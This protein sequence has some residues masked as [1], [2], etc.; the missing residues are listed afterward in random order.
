MGGRQSVEVATPNFDRN[1][2]EYVQEGRALPEEY[3]MFQT[4][5]NLKT[6]A[7][8]DEYE[9]VWPNEE[10]YSYYMKSFNW[11][12]GQSN[13][14]QSYG[15]V[16]RRREGFCSNNYS[17]NVYIEHILTRLSEIRDIPYPDNLYVLMEALEGYAKVFEHSKFFLI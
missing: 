2:W 15:I 3:G 7:K 1:E 11:R 16:E 8:V 10:E 14:V 12:F 4:L 13:V 6:G 9:F 17:A 5:R